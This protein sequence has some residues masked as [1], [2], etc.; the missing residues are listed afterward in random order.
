[1]TQ[2][3]TILVLGA[4][5]LA[6]RA[7]VKRLV[8]KTRFPVIAAG[9]N[10]EK[11]QALDIAG[12]GD[13]VRRL[14]LDA[15]DRGALRDA[16]ASAKIVINAI[17]PY[18]VHGAGIA[19][20]AIDAGCSVIDCAN[21]QIHYR[22]LRALDED[23]REKGVLLVTGAGVI[24][25]I[26]T[27]LTAKLLDDVAGGGSVDIF[28]L[29]FQHAYEDSGFGSVMGGILDACHRPTA[30]VDGEQTPVV[31]GRSHR[32]VGFDAPFGKRRVF[33][34]PTIDTLALS[35]GYSMRD[36]HTWFY[37]GEQPMWLFPVIRLLQ[38]QRRAWAY[39]LLEAIA[40]PLNDKEFQRARKEGL[41]REVLLTVSV[42]NGETARKA[43]M[44]F[45]DGASPTAFL[46]VRLAELLASGKA[47]SAG[48]ATPI[49]LVSFDGLGVD[50]EAFVVRVHLP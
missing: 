24:P 19:R 11:L 13:R 46:P 48:L 7:I 4:Y 34:I 29:Q 10:A 30:V 43:T 35:A 32:T 31:L 33:E 42:A 12:A 5:G 40:R 1:M 25:G 17:G 8:E 18:A 22:N 39:R 36:V 44:V 15:A 2:T 3:A 21:E 28:Y 49:D 38:P 16:C 27:L 50:A 9:R 26:S 47:G 14:V 6:G 41:P 23:A 20:I 45:T 37:L